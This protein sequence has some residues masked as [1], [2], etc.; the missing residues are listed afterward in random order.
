L[1]CTGWLDVRHPVVDQK[2]VFRSP[3]LMVAGACGVIVQLLGVGLGE[4]LGLG[5]G[6]GLDVEQPDS[7]AVA[8]AVRPP[9]ET[10][11][12]QVEDRKLEPSTR[13]RP[14]DPAVPRAVLSGEVAVTVAPA[15]APLPSTRT[16]PELS[17]ARE[18]DRANALDGVSNNAA[19][20][21]NNALRG[22]GPPEGVG[23]RH[24]LNTPGRCL[25]A[26]LLS[27]D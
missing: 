4:G 20:S 2:Y 27:Y 21:R 22:M 13:K 1:N 8:L 24:E 7:V 19:G 14:S 26:G 18:T 15:A 11:T 5:L 12:L 3:T 23:G 6:L 25:S 17:S 9:S 10:V 16:W